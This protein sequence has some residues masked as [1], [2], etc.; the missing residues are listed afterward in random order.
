M[1][2][3]KRIHVCME[4]GSFLLSSV[5]STFAGHLREFHDY[6]GTALNLKLFSSTII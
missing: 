3:G 2:S 1:K 5:L 4:D 6:R